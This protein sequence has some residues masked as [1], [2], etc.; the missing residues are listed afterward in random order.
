MAVQN[1]ADLTTEPLILS[2]N[3]DV[4]NETIAQD[5]QRA[6]ALLHNTVMALIAATGLW[7]P[8]NSVVGTDG[9]AVPRGIYLGDDIDAADLVDGDV[10][11][12]PILIGDATV[13]ENLVVYDDDTLSADSVIG[14]ASIWA[15]NGR[16]ALK[17]TANIRLEDTVAISEHEN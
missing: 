3:S 5:A 7:V 15:I 1:R 17:E 13:N 14:A 12:I 4:R 11:N 16:A 8:W 10:E 2:D 9:S 6:T